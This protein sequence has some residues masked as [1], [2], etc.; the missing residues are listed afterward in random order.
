ME[1][2]VK[3][4][5]PNRFIDSN[6]RA[7]LDGLEIDCFIPSL[8]LGFEYNGEQHY[9]FPNAFHKTEEQFEAQQQR[10]IE[11]NKLAEEREIK[12]ITIRYDEELSEEL[13]KNK[14]KDK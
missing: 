8:N 5:F 1:N 6:T 14:L 3:D 2:L 4:M 13:I 7:F 9:N 10:D 11:K 12:L